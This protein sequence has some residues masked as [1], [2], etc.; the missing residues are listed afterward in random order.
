MNAVTFE[1]KITQIFFH[2]DEFCKSFNAY[3]ESQSIG[4]KR[5][6]RQPTMSISEICTILVLYHLSGFK[7]FKA[8][9]LRFVMSGNCD[10]YFKKRLSYNRFI[11]LVPKSL[12]YMNAFLMYERCVAGSGIYYADSK[13]VV[14]CHNRRIHSNKV[15][16]GIADRGHCSVGFFYGFKL[17]LVI[18]HLGKLVKFK[19]TKASM[20]DNNK[21]HMLSFFAGIAGKMYA[22]K[23]YINQTAWSELM[24]NGLQI[25]TKIKKN[26]KNKLMT[27]EDK[28]LLSKRGVIESAFNLMI[29]QCDL[30]HSRHRSFVNAFVAMLASLIAYSYLDHL[31]TIL[32]DFGNFVTS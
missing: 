3:L 8:F 28:L 16:K 10:K 25:F 12:L 17:H 23:G 5:R 24:N 30:E 21:D 26:M 15:F 27:L 13:K 14:V 9:Y 4:R 1:N 19:F 18:D 22:D 32:V 11:E 20:A 7:C 29:T 31:P 2:I 6:R